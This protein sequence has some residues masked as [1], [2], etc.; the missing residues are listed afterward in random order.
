MDEEFWEE[1]IN[2]IREMREGK[3]DFINLDVRDVCVC[4]VSSNGDK[5]ETNVD[6]S[7]LDTKNISAQLG[8]RQGETNK[9]DDEIY[10]CTESNPP[11]LFYPDKI[12]HDRFIEDAA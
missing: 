6:V 11:S 5:K 7:S 4:F 8:A 1:R 3:I 2:G 10:T 9:Y 12:F